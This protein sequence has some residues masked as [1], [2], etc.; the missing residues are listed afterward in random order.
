MSE[1]EQPARGEDGQGVPAHLTTASN[2]FEADM[3][4]GRLSEAGVNAWQ[5]GALGPRSTG[6]GSCDIYVEE[7]DLDAARSALESAE[8][9]SEADVI[10][11]EQEDA[12]QREHPD[13]GESPDSP[14][15]RGA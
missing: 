3:I 2:E 13:G 12:A 5:E 9:V 4:L 1:A 10:A 6:F 8:G 15:D 11:A 7:Q 14:P